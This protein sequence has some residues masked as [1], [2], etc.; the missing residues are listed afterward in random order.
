M[1]HQ[2]PHYKSIKHTF[3][4]H[5]PCLQVCVIAWLTDQSTSIAQTFVAIRCDFFSRWG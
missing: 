1:A 4:T 5:N 2:E 3:I